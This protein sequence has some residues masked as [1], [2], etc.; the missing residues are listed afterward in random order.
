MIM[1]DNE[2]A[3]RE[4][5]LSCTYYRDHALIGVSVSPNWKGFNSVYVA[6]YVL[7]LSMYKCY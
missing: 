6:M 2:L 3:M 5:I 4:S 1:M 7:S